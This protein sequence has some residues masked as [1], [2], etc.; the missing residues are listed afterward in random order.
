MNDEDVPSAIPK[1]E[2]YK[3]AAPVAPKAW[4][5]NIPEAEIANSI[6]STDIDTFALNVLKQKAIQEDKKLNRIVVAKQL[7]DDL[8]FKDEFEKIVK[9]FVDDLGL[10]PYDLK[11]TFNR[12]FIK[13]S[14]LWFVSKDSFVGLSKTH[15]SGIF[16]SVL[17]LDKDL[18]VRAIKFL[19]SIKEK[20][21]VLKDNDSEIYT[22]AAANGGINFYHVG[23]EDTSLVKENYS[24]EVQ[25]EFE[26][27]AE[28]LQS[29][30]PDGRLCILQG[31]PGT[32]KTF[33]IRGLIDKIK[34]C[35]FVVIPPQYLPE[36]SGPQF[37]SALLELKDSVA[38]DNDM[39]VD[40]ILSDLIHADRIGLDIFAPTE[41]SPGSRMDSTE[42]HSF[43][44]SIFAKVKSGEAEDTLSS[45]S[46]FDHKVVL[47]KDQPTETIKKKHASIVLVV[48]DADNN[49]A[50]RDPGSYTPI[51]TVLNFADGI[52]GRNLDI[53]LICSTN[54]KEF[55]ID[56]A[57]TRPGRL[58]SRLS[59]NALS[60]EESVEAYKR[61][62]GE[63]VVDDESMRYLSG[64]KT[65]A[66]IYKLALN[67]K[68]ALRKKSDEPNKE[69]FG[70]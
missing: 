52:I 29:P 60:E 65:I 32:G 63:K 9:F 33:L 35:V 6:Y 66:E 64:G 49:L 36:L 16:S 3:K 20:N 45:T 18:M 17:T 48:E 41:G 57:L 43:D 47:K 14:A 22:M 1:E 25:K 54:L 46:D 68:D 27:M 2:F 50:K 67:R 40:D 31:V 42:D 61:I 19:Q 26:Y 62:A 13:Q 51:S 7:S 15:K 38:F 4:Y 34:N 23:S 24:K 39:C 55:E 10:R 70:F 8:N 56:D 37:I 53:R 21:N 11:Y 5:E 12:G 44:S 30:K 59:I 69:K 58:L 28:Q